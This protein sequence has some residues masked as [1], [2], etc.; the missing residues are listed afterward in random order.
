VTVAD[1]RDSSGMLP[2]ESLPI[3]VE[4]PLKKQA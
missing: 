4:I 1:G 3:F 2:K